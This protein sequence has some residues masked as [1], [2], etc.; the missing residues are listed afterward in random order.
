MYDDILGFMAMSRKLW[1]NVDVAYVD[2]SNKYNTK[3]PTG[4]MGYYGCAVTLT[5]NLWAISLHII[6]KVS[7]HG[8]SSASCAVTFEACTYINILN[9]I[10]E[11]N[12]FA[13]W[14]TLEPHK[15]VTQG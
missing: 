15:N 14:F 3:I 2:N 8:A 6:S 13:S 7:I 12:N 1:S 5:Q 9:Y 4:I 10:S 11:E